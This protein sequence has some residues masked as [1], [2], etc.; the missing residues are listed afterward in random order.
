M[1][2][3]YYVYIYIYIYIYI[4]HV[5]DLID[6]CTETFPFN[7]LPSVASH[8]W[9]SKAWYLLRRKC[10]SVVR[11]TQRYRQRLSN[12]RPLPGRWRIDGSIQ[13]K[14]AVPRSV[15]KAVGSSIAVCLPPK[16]V[17]NLWKSPYLPICPS[18]SIEKCRKTCVNGHYLRYSSQGTYPHQI[19]QKNPQRWIL[20]A[21]VLVHMEWKECKPRAEFEHAWTL[22]QPLSA[23]VT[24]RICSL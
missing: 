12:A 20:W 22:C 18:I 1:I 5:S 7:R 24:W 9:Q 11:R 8:P 21:E 4:N 23:F 14:M 6:L 19:S 2:I 17:E 10:P 3:L 13:L 15:R 16:L